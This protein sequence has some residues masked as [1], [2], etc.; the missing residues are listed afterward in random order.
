M[1]KPKTDHEDSY[2]LWLVVKEIPAEDLPDEGKRKTSRRRLLCECVG[3]NR[4][5]S[6]LLEN[7]RRGKSKGCSQCR[8]RGLLMEA[9]GED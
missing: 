5:F 1:P 8:N 3:C 7:L 9:Q 2:G 6:V 4:E